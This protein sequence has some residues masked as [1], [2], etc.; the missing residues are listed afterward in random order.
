MPTKTR[1]SSEDSLQ[2]YRPGGEVYRNGPSLA[3]LASINYGLGGVAY[4]IY[5]LARSRR[6]AGLLDLAHDWIGRALALSPREDAFYNPAIEIDFATVGDGSLFHSTSGLHV[7]HALICAARGRP[8]DASA[9]ER[10]IASFVEESRKPSK[11]P[12]LTLGTASL[13]LGCAELMESAMP[14]TRDGESVRVRGDEIAADL[15]G[16]LRSDRVAG[17][18]RL[19]FLGIAHGWGGLLFALLRWSRALEQPV[20]PAIVARLDELADLGV[21]H[22]GGTCWP[23]QN[24]NRQVMPG[25]CNGTAGHAILFALAC[26]MLGT[27]RYRELA[28][29]AARSAWVIRTAVGSL[30]CG[31]AGNAY[32]Y[33]AVH[34]LTGDGLWLRRARTAARR[35]TQAPTEIHPPDALYKGAVGVTVLANDLEHPTTASMPLFEPTRWRA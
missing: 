26:E 12:D 10:A 20:D 25:W 8:G 4:A 29:E 32:A 28:V 15:L 17:S 19:R 5:R 16:I 6:D 21:P 3:P 7:V 30:C 11:F 35:A 13:L 33:L 23:I 22:D 34:R 27:P 14:G 9:A 2:R 18:T 31:E 1:Q 24:D